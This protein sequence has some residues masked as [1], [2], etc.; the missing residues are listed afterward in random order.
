M[1]KPME[2]KMTEV[3]QVTKKKIRQFTEEMIQIKNDDTLNKSQKI[4]KLYEVTQDRGTIA[5]LLQIRY[6]HVRNVLITPLKKT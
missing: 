3:T 1:N 4:R 6:Q 5:D 2:H